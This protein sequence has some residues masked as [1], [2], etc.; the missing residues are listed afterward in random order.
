MTLRVRLFFLVLAALIPL[1]ATQV[2]NQI[3]FR[4]ERRHEVERMAQ[5][6]AK[7]VAGELDQIAAGMHKFLLAT[8]NSAQSRPG[9]VDCNAYLATLI[10]QYPGSLAIGASDP[11]GNVYCYARP[12]PA[13]SLG[14]ADR[15]HFRLA[16]STG[17]FAVGEYMI[18]KETG[19]KALAFAYPLPRAS[20]GAPQGVVFASL[21]LEWLTDYLAHKGTPIG[22]SLTVVDRNGTILVRLP[23]RERMGTP[24]P[25]PWQAVFNAAHPQLLQT[26]DPFT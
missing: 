21:G 3:M 15:A 25:T 20:S 24:V 8:A 9:A 2:Y 26:N 14:T 17:K 11:N 18:G 4:Q 7:L 6:E 22:Y 5:L 16:L 19:K 13:G 1:L 10:E 23:E 12:F